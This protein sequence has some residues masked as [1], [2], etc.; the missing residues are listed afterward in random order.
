MMV[1]RNSNYDTFTTFE[2]EHALRSPFAARNTSTTLRAAINTVDPCTFKSILYGISANDGSTSM[3]SGVDTGHLRG[4]AW[5][6]LVQ[7]EQL[8]FNLF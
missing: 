5:I 6:L 2:S 1:Q 3:V 8:V 4:W 7:E